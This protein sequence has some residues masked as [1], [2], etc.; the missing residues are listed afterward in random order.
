LAVNRHA[1]EMPAI[2]SGFDGSAAATKTF[3]M[4]RISICLVAIALIAGS[5]T[6]FAQ[7]GAKPA[8]VGAGTVTVKGKVIR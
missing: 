8:N 7:G 5:G 6:I 4:T 1:A 2:G 3:I